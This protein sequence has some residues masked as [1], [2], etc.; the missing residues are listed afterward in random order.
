MSVWQYQNSD[1]QWMSYDEETNVKI[2]RA[3]NRKPN[4]KCIIDLDKT[5]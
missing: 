5:V 1:G 3:Y 2:E 4:G